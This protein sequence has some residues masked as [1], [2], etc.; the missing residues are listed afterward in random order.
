MRV[1]ISGASGFLGSHLA[2]CLTDRG[3]EV[4]RLVRRDSRRDDEVSWDPA[5]GRLAPETL[6]TVDAVVNL[7]G[8]GLGDHRWT[9]HY[10]EIIRGSRIGSTATLAA[11]IAAA[12]PRPRTLLSASGIGW[13]GDTGARE[14]TEGSPAGTGFIPD[15]CQA[16]EAATGTAAAAGTRVVCLRTAPVLDASGGL[17]KPLLPLFRLGLGGR[18]GSGRQYMS[19]ITLADWLAAVAFLLTASGGETVTGPVNVTAPH[20][21]TNAEFTRTLA[22]ILH[23]PAVLAVPRVALRIGVGEFTSEMVA[24]QRG[25]PGVLT[26]AGYAFG[27]RTIDEGLRA[28]LTP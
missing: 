4:V 19:W 23:R 6:H 25:L 2:S 13:Y 12:D 28:A 22:G 10:K 17:L 9:R 15:L 26:D 14:V 8:A 11:A 21:V 18:L 3:H 20:P 5:Q 7:A 27:H 24:S 1:M 16:W